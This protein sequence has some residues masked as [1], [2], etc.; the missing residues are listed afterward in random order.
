MFTPLSRIILL[1]L[2][3]ALSVVAAVFNIY[4]LLFIACLGSAFLLWGYFRKG[5]V[6][7]ALARLRAEEYKEAETI[8]EQTTKPERLD[9]KQKAYYLFVKGFIAREKDQY[10]EARIFLE[11][12]LNEGIRNQNDIAMALLALTDMEMVKNNKRQAE[13]YFVQMKGLKVKPSLM[14]DIRKMQEWLGV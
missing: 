13:A 12:S 6:S 10:E 11:E 8:I 1:L 2:C 3:A 7:L 14:P 4:S 9:K 5:S